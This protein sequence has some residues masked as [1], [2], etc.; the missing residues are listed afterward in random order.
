M[1][2]SQVIFSGRIS[3]SARGQLIALVALACGVAGLEAEGV[4]QTRVGESSGDSILAGEGD[5]GGRRSL[6]ELALG[7]AE[8]RAVLQGPDLCEKGRQGIAGT[9]GLL[10][11]K[12][13][14]AGGL[15]H[16]QLGALLVAEEFE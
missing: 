9:G 16:C 10:V 3:K 11:G 5:E 2:V 6:E 1:W 8:I 14:L 15:L 4:G 7:V 13:G 12:S